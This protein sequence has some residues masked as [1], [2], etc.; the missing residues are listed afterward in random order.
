MG[1][2]IWLHNDKNAYVQMHNAI[3]QFNYEV[4][5]IIDRF[6]PGMDA[7]AK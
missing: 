7:T 3:K 2:A 5:G 1:S 6:R 4:D